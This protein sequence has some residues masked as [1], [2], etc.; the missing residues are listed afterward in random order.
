MKQYWV[1]H[2]R[3]PY[4]ERLRRLGFVVLYPAV[5]DYVFLEAT[6]DNKKIVAQQ[7]DL[8]VFFLRA[9]RKMKTVS[10]E[11]LADIKQKT[12]ERLEVG[13]SIIV[14]A[15]YC[16]ALEGE[17]TDEGEQKVKCMLEGWNRQYHVWLDRLEV[18]ARDLTNEEKSGMLEGEGG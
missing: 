13:A 11:E 17:I 12:T 7:Q 5:D 1:A 4:F 14:V 16:E 10:E 9:G 6:D 15:G 3:G 18:A 2:V 8:G